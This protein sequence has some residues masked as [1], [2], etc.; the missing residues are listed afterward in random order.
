[1]MINQRF[2]SWIK[3]KYPHL[4]YINREEDMGSEGLR[5]AKLSYYPDKM[6]I[7]YRAVTKKN[8]ALHK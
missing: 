1:P 5:K 4:I 8:Y 7:K 2:A 3:D 6:A